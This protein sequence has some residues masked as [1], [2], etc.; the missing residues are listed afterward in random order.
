M[1]DETIKA[2]KDAEQKSG[3][4]VQKAE[5]RAAEIVAEAKKEAAGWE[6]QQIRGA[7]EEAKRLLEEEKQKGEEFLARSKKE[8]EEEIAGV[9]KEAA[10]K[11]EEAIR[12]VIGE[13]I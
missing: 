8:S 1:L 12:L 10:G 7:R 9:R 13:I 2:V 3:M 5:L 4:L 6:E 11:E